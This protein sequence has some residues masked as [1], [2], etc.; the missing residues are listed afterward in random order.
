MVSGLKAG[1]GRWTA[2]L[3]KVLVAAFLVTPAATIA[4]GT[5]GFPV[6]TVL[7][8]DHPI[9]SGDYAWNADGVPRGSTQ[10]VV[11]L[12]AQR[13]YVY[14]NGIEIGRTSIIYGADDMPT[15]TGTFSILQKKADHVSNLYNAPMPY[16]LRLTW[17]GVAI[18][19]SEVD[20]EYAT[21]GCVGIPEEFAAL[22]FR[23][24]RVGDRVLVT[25]RWMP[26]Y[27]GN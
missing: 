14:R 18:H 4:A 2:G 25:N 26:A 21:H 1:A 17:D 6:T 5:A 27:Y 11:D 8:L 19:A 7:R 3:V 22:L 20:D 9:E 15:P 12:A 23:E 16:M 13:L 24:A 10:I